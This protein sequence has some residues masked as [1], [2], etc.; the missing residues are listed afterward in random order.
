MTVCGTL[1]MR[2]TVTAAFP[3]VFCKI[4]AKKISRNSRGITF[5]EN[6]FCM[7]VCCQEWLIS[8]WLLVKNILFLLLRPNAMRHFHLTWTGKKVS[9]HFCNKPEY[10]CVWKKNTSWERQCDNCN[11]ISEVF[12]SLGVFITSFLLKYLGVMQLRNG[13]GANVS[14]ISGWGSGCWWLCTI[15]KAT[16]QAGSKDGIKKRK[17]FLL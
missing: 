16:Y 11:D 9:L 13:N 10:Q 3:L 6:H 7:I 12:Q 15:C 17:L 14:A 5:C 1:F 4:G 8:Y 2:L